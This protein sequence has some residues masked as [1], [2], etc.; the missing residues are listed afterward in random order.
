MRN[1][2]RVYICEYVL[3]WL[4]CGQFLDSSRFYSCYRKY[5]FSFGIDIDSHL[6]EKQ[7]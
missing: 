7:R 1:G 3:F 5:W 4:D 2:P 6:S